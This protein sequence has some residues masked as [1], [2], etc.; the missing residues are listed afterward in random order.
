MELD[1][2]SSEDLRSSRM[3]SVEGRGRARAAWDAYVK[4]ANKLV[5]PLVGKQLD[6]VIRRWAVG[7]V[8]ESYGFW[9]LWQIHGGFEG[10]ER[11]GMARTTIFRRVKRFRQLTG[12][13]PDEYELPGITVDLE[14][15]WAGAAAALERDNQAR[16][17]L[18]P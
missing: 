13:H 5:D 16:A 17:S 15:Y 18:Q 8:E 2:Q 9:L 10:L 1:G 4:G 12:F 6:G 3:P 11:L 14:V 7:A